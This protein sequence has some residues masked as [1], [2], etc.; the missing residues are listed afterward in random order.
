M[1]FFEKYIRIKKEDHKI[2]ILI[3]E[4]SQKYDKP[5][6]KNHHKYN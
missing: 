3:N 1:Y 4:S 6:A 5:N 2:I